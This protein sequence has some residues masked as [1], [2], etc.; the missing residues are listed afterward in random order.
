[1]SDQLIPTWAIHR[2]L[3]EWVLGFAS[4]SVAPVALFFISIIEAF[5]PFVPPDVLLIPMCVEHRRKSAWFAVIAVSGSVIGALIGYFVIASMMA[6]G[7]EW[8]LGADKI[9]MAVNE[10]E[11]RGSVYVFIAALTPVPFFALT[12][13]AGIAKLNFG[14]FLAA[15]IIGRS[16]RYGIEALVTY[17]IGQQAKVFID[18]WFNAITF[19]ACVVVLLGWYLSTQL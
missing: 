11:K 16:L 3:Y 12:I 15:C 7:A 4:T 8:I 9:E 13:A 2:R 14:I 17:W 10:F 5:F 19:I 6:G 1:M 18:K